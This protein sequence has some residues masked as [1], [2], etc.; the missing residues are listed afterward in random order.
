MIS[1]RQHSLPPPTDRYNILSPFSSRPPFPTTLHLHNHELNSYQF[2]P[3]CTHSLKGSADKSVQLRNDLRDNNSLF[4]FPQPP[5][6]LHHVFTIYILHF[7]SSPL[8]LLSSISPSL[9]LYTPALPSTPSREHQPQM[10]LPQQ[11][12]TPHTLWLSNTHT[13]YPLA[14]KHT[15]CKLSLNVTQLS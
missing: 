3:S 12:H 8:L 7:S 13:P 4:L 5:F 14:I 15:T 6:L 11:T 9:S 2:F 10:L 1:Q